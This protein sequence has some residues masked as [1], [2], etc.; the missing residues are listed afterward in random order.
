MDRYMK[1]F[2]IAALVYFGLASLGGIVIGTGADPSWLRFLHVHFNL[3]GFMSMMIYGIGY[4]ILPRF[5][6]KVLRFPGLLPVHFYAANIGL[7]GMVAAY[8]QRPSILFDAFAVLE[9]ASVGIFI[10]NLVAT[11]LMEPKEEKRESEAAVKP[12]LP[13]M[14]VGEV[15]EKYPGIHKVFVENGIA[16]L[17]DPQH[18]EQVKEM[19]VTVMMASNKHGVP[20][21]KL[22]VELNDYIGVSV[23]VTSGRTASGE[24]AATGLRRGERIQAGHVLGDIIDTYPEA[25]PVFRE[26]YGDGCFSCPGQ[27]TE[28]VNMSAM[29]H[30]VEEGQIL[31]ALNRVVDEVLR[32]KSAESK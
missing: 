22:I 10:F 19:P 1:G 28:S 13:G 23:R 5:N 16:A 14:R 8:P 27:A 2:V 21:E 26:F 15:L 24:M 32:A 12:I 17:A 20:L 30:N 29:M 3:L 11:L 18:R 31:Q 4:F 7:I 9:G 6:G 25:E